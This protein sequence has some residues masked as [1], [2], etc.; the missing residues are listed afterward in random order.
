MYIIKKKETNAK[1][2]EEEKYN[3][4]KEQIRPQRKRRVIR[5][6]GKILESV[7]FAVI[8]GGV[9]GIVFWNVNNKLGSSASSA[10]RNIPP[11]KSYISTAVPE[12]TNVPETGSS[13]EVSKGDMAVIEE[14]NRVAKK[15]SSIG[16]AFSES[17]VRVINKNKKSAWYQYSS[18]SNAD[19]SGMFIKETSR[20]YYILASESALVPEAVA[21]EFDDGET[22]DAEYLSGDS[23][24][25]LSVIIIAKKDVSGQRRRKIVI[26]QFGSTMSI[27]TG[28]NIIVTGAPNGIIYSVMT[29]NIIKPDIDMPVT[30]NLVSVFATNILYTEGC[31][32][33]VLNTKGRVIGFIT[34]PCEGVTGRNGIGFIGIS[35]I[36]D[37]INSMVLEEE[38]PYFGIEG[39]DVD[40]KTALAHKLEEGIYITSVYPDSPAYL[41]GMR[42]AD[43]ITQVGREEV[44]SL[45]VFHNILK[46]H[47]KGD[48]ITVTVLRKSSDKNNHHKKIEV[49]LG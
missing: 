35:S 14:H 43:V 12:S 27:P 23:N 36:L 9:A 10:D 16:D 48:T 22:V 21:I 15:L 46:K 29:G 18:S 20:Y 2:H 17:L 1:K 41:G 38:I 26:P 8:F 7:V 44:F 33:V 24:I 39:H 6:F 47:N 40:A 3:F 37:I 25:G 45:S 28:S 31:N 5:F 49:V 42:V 19:I 30:D 11:V 4:I 34:S 32:G 13:N